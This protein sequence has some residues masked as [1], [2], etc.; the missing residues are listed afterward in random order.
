MNTCETTHSE[1]LNELFTALAKSQAMILTASKDK[2]NPFFKSKYT[3]LSSVWSACREPL[4]SNGLSVIQTVE[5]SKDALFIKTWL[6]HSSGQWMTSKLPLLLMK[7]DPQSL[8]SAISY[9]RRYSLM[10]MVGVVSDDDDDGEAAMKHSRNHK[11]TEIVHSAEV[12]QNAI[13]KFYA[14]FDNSEEDNIYDYLTA[15]CTKYNKSHYEAIT[16]DF[17]DS[18]LFFKSLTKW[19]EKRAKV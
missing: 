8:G 7:M 16:Q 4:S 2:V 11:E 9:G 10:A 14:Q 6:G 5:G 17:T 1:Q 15:Y 19:K 13:N 18:S 12:Q 3:D